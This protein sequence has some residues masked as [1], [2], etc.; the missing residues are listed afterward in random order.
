MTVFSGNPLLFLILF[1]LFIPFINVEMSYGKYVSSSEVRAASLLIPIIPIHPPIS[2]P[3]TD[4]DCD[5]AIFAVRGREKCF[6]RRHEIP[7][8]LNTWS[9]GRCAAHDE[10]EKERITAQRL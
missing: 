3:Y 4:Q 2:F 7:R 6:G 5:D 8:V 1:I 10:R 9:G